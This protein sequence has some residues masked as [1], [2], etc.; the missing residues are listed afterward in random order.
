MTVLPQVGAYPLKGVGGLPN[1]D[2]AK[3]GE[4]WTNQRANGNIVPG[5]A[6]FP[7]NV[8]GY[9][10]QKT[11]GGADTVDERQVAVA[12]RTI[13][14]PDTNP[15][16]LYSDWQ[17]PNEIV[18]KMIADQDYVRSYHT[19]VMHFTLVVPDANGYAPGELIGWNPTG[20]RPLGKAAG[21][22]AWDHANNAHANTIIFECREWRP[23]GNVTY[24][25]AGE[26]VLTVRFLRSNQ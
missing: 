4:V 22:G 16:S 3:S 10:N 12:L 8:S 20:T 5:S 19:G 21:E 15:G 23:Y 26:G 9:L 25:T 14:I 11:V 1:A 6:I 18:N 24:G 7:V 13:M 17:G 2:V